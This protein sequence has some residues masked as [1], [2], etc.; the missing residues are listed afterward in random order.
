MGD[1]K[2]VPS[3]HLS[4]ETPTPLSLGVGVCG[5]SGMLCLLCV[6]SVSQWDF[7]SVF[8]CVRLL[9]ALQALFLLRLRLSLLRKLLREFRFLG[10]LLLLLPAL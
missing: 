6:E 7:G 10:L 9:P 8:I 5:A 2:D 1:R 4:I 3:Y